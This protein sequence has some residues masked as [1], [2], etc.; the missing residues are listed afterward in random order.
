[1]AEMSLPG[2]L[3]VAALSIVLIP[4]VFLV[5]ECQADRISLRGGGQIRGKVIPDTAHPGRVIVLTETGK[6]PLNLQ[7]PQILEVVSEPSALDE[8]VVKRA[9]VQ[10]TAQAQ[11]DL[12]RWCKEHKLADLATVH[13]ELAVAQDKEFGPAHKELGHVLFGDRWLNADEVREAQGLVKY[14]G[15]W[16]TKEEK[17]HREA[18]VAESAVQTSWVRRIRILR[19]AIASGA[20]D[21]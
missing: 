10:P 12:G 14:K 1:M 18:L 2:N 8:Y 4:T 21:R 6:T 19:Q 15:K 11:Y 13:Y 20:S 9:K 7:K 16:I 17:E 3:R 5:E